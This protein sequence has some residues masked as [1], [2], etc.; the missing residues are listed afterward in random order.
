MK[1]R[2][3]I[4]IILLAA[5]AVII[6]FVPYRTRTAEDGGT[7]EYIALA[8]RIVA[9]NRIVSSGNG[10]PQY[11]KNTNVYWYPDSMKTLDEL[12]KAEHSENS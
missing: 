7:R 12:W 1:L 9:W 2:K 10:E 8:C 4:V 5:A 11:Y 6:P 3:R